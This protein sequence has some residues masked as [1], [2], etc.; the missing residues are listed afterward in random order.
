MAIGGGGAAGAY[1]NG[2]FNAEAALALNLVMGNIGAPGGLMPGAGEPTSM[3]PANLPAIGTL[4]DWRQAA[5]AINNG[6]T[7]LVVVHNAD[8]VYGLP[9]GVGF[10]DALLNENVMVFSSSSF[11]DETT[12]MAD[13]VIPDRGCAGRLGRR[14]TRARNR[15]T[16]LRRSAA[17]GESAQRS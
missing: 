10:G 2:K 11:V 1:S 15:R 5:S 9:S 16:H 12:A 13:V 3:T 14:Y 6:S 8:P 7:R 4:N 17:S